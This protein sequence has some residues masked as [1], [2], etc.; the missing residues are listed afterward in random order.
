MCVFL[1]LSRGPAH[2]APTSSPVSEMATCHTLSLL[3][4]GDMS[5]CCI[6]QSGRNKEPVTF[7]CTVFPRLRPGNLVLFWIKLEYGN[8][9]CVWHI[10]N[11]NKKGISVWTKTT[12]FDSQILKCRLYWGAGSCETCLQQKLLCFPSS[13]INYPT[14]LNER[15]SFLRVISLKLTFSPCFC[16]KIMEV[17]MKLQLN[18]SNLLP[19]FV[20]CSFFHCFLMCSL[21]KS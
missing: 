9:K 19:G 2:A 11:V 13:C 16:Y 10:N 5:N 6:W 21:Q 15:H 12:V 8:R 20:L 1:Q 18:K 17:I 7:I 3:L 14:P 4:V